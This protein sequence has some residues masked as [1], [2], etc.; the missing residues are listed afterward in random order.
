MA[1]IVSNRDKIIKRLRRIKGQVE[2]VE[3][4]IEG[5]QD[6]F[7]VLQSLAACRGALNGLFAELTQEHLMNHVVSNSVKPTKQDKAALELAE[8]I[9]TYWK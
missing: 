3:R 9:K 5:E 8:I 6:C 4:L 1:H 2:G 7:K